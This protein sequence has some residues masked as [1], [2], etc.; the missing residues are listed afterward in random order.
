MQIGNIAMIEKVNLGGIDILTPQN[1]E[2]FI[3]F[4]IKNN[5][6][7][8]GKLIA[9]NAE[10]MVMAE[11][12]PEI[13]NLLS[14]NEYNYADGIGVVFAIR[15]KY[16]KYH[17]LQR[18]A[19]VDLWQALMRRAGELS[20]PVF[21]IGAQNDTL[22]DVKNKLHSWKVNIVGMHNGYFEQYQEENI[23]HQ[24]VQS[25]AKFVTVAMGSPKQEL[26]MLKLQQ[27]YPEALYMGVGGTYEVFTGRVKRAPYGWRKMNLEWL[28]RLL[29]QPTRWRR[30]L[31]LLQYIYYYLSGK[32]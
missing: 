29:S 9:V 10:K 1:E 4:L 12:N 23:I 6:I 15:R 8:A 27:R 20:I 26:L 16:K 17:K 13:K 22:L 24:V 3:R 5:E 21:L 18:I 2:Q 25:Q 7:K 31:N 11:K 32:V 19:G 14:R 30:Q 28:Y